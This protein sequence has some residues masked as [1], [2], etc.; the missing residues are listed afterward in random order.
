MTNTYKCDHCGHRYVGTV[1]S[2]PDDGAIYCEGQE[3]C[4][5]C[6]GPQATIICQ[7]CGKP[8]CDCIN[9]EKVFKEVCITPCASGFGEY[10][11]GEANGDGY[12]DIGCLLA[13]VYDANVDNYVVEEHDW[14]EDENIRGR[15]HNE[16]QLVCM[17]YVLTGAD[18]YRY[19]GIVEA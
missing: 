5:R 13:Q 9:T 17:W 7:Y 19:Y 6:D 16:D 15:I 8:T 12:A 18:E 4:P 3:G 14:A 1:N 11:V 2:D 10:E